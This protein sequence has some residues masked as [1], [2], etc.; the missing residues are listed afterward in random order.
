[1]TYRR[2]LALLALALAATAQAQPPAN[3]PPTTWTAQP[4]IQQ[5]YCY[6]PQPVPAPSWPL[7][8]LSADGNKVRIQTADGAQATCEGLTIA[9]GGS[10][11]VKVTVSDKRINVESG[12]EPQIGN[13]HD[14]LRAS[15]DRVTRAGPDGMTLTLE[16][17]ARLMLVRKGKKADLVAE[18]IAVNLVTWH[19][20]S[21]LT[22][23]VPPSPLIGPPCSVTPCPATSYPVGTAP[24]APSTTPNQGT[25]PE[26]PPPSGR[27][28]DAPRR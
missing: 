21:D 12:I 16:G 17:N 14:S 7:W 23:S 20:E 27:P 10:E 1:M 5:A 2:L 4:Q 18:R 28:S 6:V 9:V 19:V 22:G 13:T 8:I 26:G 11:A 15:A 24:L 3:P 25:E